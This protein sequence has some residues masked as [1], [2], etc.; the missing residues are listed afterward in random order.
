MDHFRRELFRQA[1]A[2]KLQGKTDE[3]IAEWAE[4]KFKEI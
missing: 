3:E 2:M 1:W 4:T